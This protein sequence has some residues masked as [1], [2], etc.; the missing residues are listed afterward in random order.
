MF[1]FS[2]LAALA[3]PLL[4][5][6][7]LWAQDTTGEPSAIRRWPGAADEAGSSLI[8][9]ARA[10][11]P[12][13]AAQQR[14]PPQGGGDR[15]GGSA[16]GPR[17]GDRGDGG[18]RVAVPRE[19][20]APRP[21]ASGGRPGGGGYVRPVPVRPYYY[22]PRPVYP[23]G[24]GAFGLG[25][26]YYDPYGWYPRGG[27]RYFDGYYGRGYGYDLGEVRLRVTPRNA[28]VFVD[29]YY[30]GTVDSYDGA[31]QGLKLESGPYHVE[32]V[33]PGYETLSFDVRITPGNRITYRGDLKPMP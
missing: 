10:A 28:Q 18:P 4:L 8:P 30:A 6:G 19:G 32:L 5:A 25:Y 14:R 9:I 21:R 33:A 7:S 29:G 16:G 15:G 26:F 2:I 27:I 23:Y 31:F 20:P 11:E 22:Y 1:R 24:Y 17:G 3:A 13:A 12:A